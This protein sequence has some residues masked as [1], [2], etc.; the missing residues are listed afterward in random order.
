MNASSVFWDSSSEVI[1]AV[2]NGIHDIGACDSSAIDEVLKAHGLLA[3]KDKLIKEILRSDPVP[4]DP[5]VVRSKWLAVS[6][7]SAS[8]D[9]A[10]GREIT[11]ALAGFFRVNPG[12]PSLER[13]TRE[14]FAEVAENLE[15]FR[16]KRQQAESTLPEP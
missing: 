3:N 16:Q 11:R 9:S 8:S 6:P 14:P 15:R 10:L 5:I 1:K 2:I 4:R 7:Y 12:L 13:T